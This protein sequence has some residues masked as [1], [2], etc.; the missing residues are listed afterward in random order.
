[1]SYSVHNTV[2]ERDIWMYS[3]GWVIGPPP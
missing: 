1:V 2:A 3:F